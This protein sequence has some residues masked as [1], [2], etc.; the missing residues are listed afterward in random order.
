M[1]P[2]ES[3]DFELDKEYY[4]AKAV[5]SKV[6]FSR[7]EWS[8]VAHRLRN[9]EPHETLGNV[10]KSGAPWEKAGADKYSLSGNS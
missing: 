9:G 3:T 7:L 1:A 4:T 10:L 5:D 8:R 6:T 2:I